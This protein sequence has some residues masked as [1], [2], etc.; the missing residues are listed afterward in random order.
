MAG[1]RTVDTGYWRIRKELKELLNQPLPGGRGFQAQQDKHIYLLC[2]EL[3]E[4]K[5]PDRG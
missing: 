3:T 2:K 1:T 4:Y 5:L